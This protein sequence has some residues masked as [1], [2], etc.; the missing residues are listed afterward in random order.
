[1]TGLKGVIPPHLLAQD[2]VL[3]QETVELKFVSS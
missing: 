1:M 3:P 2:L